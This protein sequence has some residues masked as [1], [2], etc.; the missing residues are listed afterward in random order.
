MT[1]PAETAGPHGDGSKSLATESK[2]G[3]TVTFVLT[4]LALG[5]AGFLAD[6]DVSTF[7]G[8]L[9]AVAAAAIGTA[10]GLLTAWATKNK[11]SQVSGF[12]GDGYI[13]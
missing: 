1:D 5:A 8:W 6:L 9:Q 2:V 12:R 11:P 4:T 13:R 10:G 3:Q 7:P